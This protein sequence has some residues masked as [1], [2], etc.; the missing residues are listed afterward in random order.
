MSF[1]RADGSLRAGDVGQGQRE[2]VDLI[3]AGGNYGWVYREGTRVNRAGAPA[4]FA[5][6]APIGEYTRSDGR[7]VIGGFVYRGSAVPELVGQ[8]VFADAFGNGG[9]RLFYM[10]PAGGPISEFQR[11]GDPLTGVVYGFGEDQAGELYVVT[12]DGGTYRV[13]PEPTALS[14][15][16]AAGL[17]LLRRQRSRSP[18]GRGPTMA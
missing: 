10:N 12:S 1:D 17:A 11:I 4:G 13:V 15:L 5:P 8:Y 2:E 18:A 3:T 7:S 9:S 14:L 6:I 16:A